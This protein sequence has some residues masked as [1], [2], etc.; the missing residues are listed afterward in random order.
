MITIR[1]NGTSHRLDVED[2]M[3]LLWVLPLALYLLTFVLTFG[4]K[5]VYKRAMWLRLLAVGLTDS[6]IGERLSR[7]P[8]TVQAHITSIYRKI[9]V[10]SRSAA[11]RYAVEH[12][13][14]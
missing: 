6:E 3:P 12:C 9:G 13:L 1:V 10:S 2:D 14:A 11:T 5:R 8:R 7:S 4:P